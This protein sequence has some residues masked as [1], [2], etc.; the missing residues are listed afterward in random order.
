MEEEG[1]GRA[2][3][4]PAQ[5]MRHQIADV[6]GAQNVDPSIDTATLLLPWH[7]AA[8]RKIFW[9]VFL[10]IFLSR[11]R[12]ASLKGGN[13]DQGPTAGSEVTE[14][15]F[16]GPT[17]CPAQHPQKRMWGSKWRQGETST[18]EKRMGGYRTSIVVMKDPGGL[19]VS[20]SGFIIIFVVL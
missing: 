7:D 14:G 18:V 13:A 11:P 5:G 16:G 20:V 1:D 4:D 2:A 8:N 9:H 19:F 15:A 6:A 17:P 3:G 10:P 12:V